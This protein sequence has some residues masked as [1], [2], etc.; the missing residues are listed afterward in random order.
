MVNLLVPLRY[1]AIGGGNQV[2][3][4]KI[5]PAHIFG[6]L[7]DELIGE[8]LI[9]TFEKEAQRKSI[10]NMLGRQLNP[11]EIARKTFSRR[12]REVYDQDQGN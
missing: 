2:H 5:K 8:D 3:H 10:V 4:Y 12:Y 6:F 9:M 7:E 1:N 11:M